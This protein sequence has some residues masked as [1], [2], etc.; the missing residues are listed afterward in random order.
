MSEIA[1]RYSTSSSATATM[2]GSETSLDEPP[3]VWRL[4]WPGGQRRPNGLAPDR[5]RLRS[6]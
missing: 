3:P 1:A 4:T 6:V 2:F 5:R